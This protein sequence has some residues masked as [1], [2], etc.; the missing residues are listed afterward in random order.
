MSTFIAVTLCISVVILIYLLNS[1]L[2]RKIKLQTWNTPSDFVLS[3]TKLPKSSV[4]V[5][6]S[7][8]LSPNDTPEQIEACITSLLDQTMKVDSICMNITERKHIDNR[9]SDFVSI[10]KYSVSDNGRELISTLL[11]EK[12]SST[13]I[14][15]VKSNQVYEK[16]FIEKIVFA[17]DDRPN[18]AIIVNGSYDDGYLVK[19][20]FFNIGFED[21]PRDMDCYAWIRK[22]LV[23]KEYNLDN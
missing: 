5:V 1:P 10:H 17:S 13:K 9:I 7:L 19:P 20:D 12:E 18:E 14:I 11:R 21:I 8:K 15:V 16:N 6:I 23:V 3:Y 2:Y 22:N 4:R